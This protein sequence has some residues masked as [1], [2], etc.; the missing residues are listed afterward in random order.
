MNLQGEGFGVIRK[1]KPKKN[2]GNNMR[3]EKELLKEPKFSF[4]GS[5]HSTLYE[6]ERKMILGIREVAEYRQKEYNEDFWECA[7]PEAING[8]LSQINKPSVE[9]AIKHYLES[10]DLDRTKYIEKYGTR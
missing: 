3:K 6:L 5:K 9:K 7:Y 1:R 4:M 8:I 10:K 2:R